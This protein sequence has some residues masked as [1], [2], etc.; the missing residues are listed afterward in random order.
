ME[1][2]I[3]LKGVC[4]TYAL[5][6]A[7]IAAL[8]GVDAQFGRGEFTALAGPSGSG[9]TTLLNIVG[10]IDK[11][12]SGRVL[13]AGR[14]VTDEPLSRLATLRNRYFGFVFQ[15]FNLIPVLT[16]YE[17]VEFPLLVGGAVPKAERRRR[18]EA[19]L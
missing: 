17:N 7:R 5:G 2:V 10:C 6:R 3:E 8:R 4:R 1:I 9:K 13:V 16:A 14:D 12:D 18:V 11:P 15:T 19:L